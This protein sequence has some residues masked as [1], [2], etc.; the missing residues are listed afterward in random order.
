MSDVTYAQAKKIK[1]TRTVRRDELYGTQINTAVC[2]MCG[3]E[4]WTQGHI[5]GITGIGE[6]NT[7]VA[8]HRHRHV[9]R[10]SGKQ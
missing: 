6:L 10:G 4:L 9:M 7:A 2:G 8:H 5:D 1:F 3:D